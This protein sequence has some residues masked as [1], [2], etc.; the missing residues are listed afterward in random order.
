MNRKTSLANSSSASAARYRITR[1]LLPLRIG[2]PAMPILL[3][4]NAMSNA[5]AQTFDAVRLYGAKIAEDGGT[6]GG[7]I[8]YAPR[9]LGAKSYRM[10]GFPLIEYSWSH[11]AFAGTGNGIG[12][13]FSPTS[14]PNAAYGLRLTADFGRKESLDARLKGLGDIKPRPELGVFFNHAL[15]EG[16]GVSTSL[17]YGSGNSQRGLVADLGLS[18]SRPVGERT[19]LGLGA[20]IS[21]V[22]ADHMQ[23][24]FGVDPSQAGKSSANGLKVYSPKA[25]VRDIR[26]NALLSYSLSARTGLSI[27][28][29][30]SRLGGEAKSSPL[31]QEASS[32]SAFAGVS[33]LF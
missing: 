17:R 24:Y 31:T 18:Y 19:M 14:N 28:L 11:G 21:L 27:G 10:Q 26:A 13:N 23:S 6:I 29:S 1:Y 16:L 15:V 7:G 30:A 20:A 2:L 33:Y 5:H 12:Y 25:G 32:L 22:N 4:L 3:A 9:Y 8:A